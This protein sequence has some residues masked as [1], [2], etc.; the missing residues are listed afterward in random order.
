MLR[1]TYR[2]FAVLLTVLLSMGLPAH[3]ADIWVA[4]DGNDY[5]PG[6]AS[7]PF[8]TVAAALRY[9]REL[10]RLQHP[11]VQK[12]IHIKI[13][14]GEYLLP[15][16]LLLRP[17][18]AG[19][20]E[21][22]TVL[23][24]ADQATP[25][26]SGGVR[27]QGWQLC[28]E[29]V[30]GLPEAA[31]GKV[32]VAPVP[33]TAGI[34]LAFRQCWV[35]GRKAVRARNIMSDED[36]PRIYAVDK[37][38]QEMCIP[39]DALKGIKEPRQLEM[40]IHQ[41]WAIANLRV[42]SFTMEGDTACLHFYQPESRIQFEHPWPEAVIDAQH[43]KNG[44]S[45]FYLTNHISFLDQPGEWYE[46]VQQGKLYY[47]PRNGETMQHAE[48]VVPALEKLVEVKG[49]ADRPVAY[50]QFKGI[51]FA[52]STWMRPSLKGHV[53]LQAGMYLLDGYKLQQPGTP[54]KKSLENQAWIGRPPAAVELSYVHHTSFEGCRFEHLAST[55]LDYIRGTHDDTV[56][57]NLFS[58]IGGTG[59]QLGTYADEA[60]ETHLP[61][62]PKDE[63]EICTRERIS[64][65]L[66]TGCT[67]EDWGCVGISAGYVRDCSITH[68]EVREVSYSGIC[69]GWGWT[70][71]PNCMRNNRIE[72]NH[73]H[74]YARHMFDV[75][76]IY[77][78]SAQPGTVITGNYIDSIYHPSYA[79]DPQHWFYFYF[80]E[81]SSYITIRDN[82]CPSE[83]FMRN[84]NGPGNT[85]QNNGPMADVRIKQTA[86]IEP[87][88]QYLFTGKRGVTEV[89][90]TIRTQKQ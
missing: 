41:M 7:R 82:W 2:F 27:I 79:H 26:L 45:A 59:I 90:E 10:R 81:G 87:R 78:L 30:P 61:Y 28:T 89:H 62:Q 69:V 42:Q 56:E 15:E 25:V 8:A 5:N 19:T 51:C 70:K 80:D 52:Y 67:N 65:N 34:P 57:G 16:T 1:N 9:A 74:H 22:P 14:G 60:F 38:K 48:V 32:W 53:P 35:N 11:S 49:L 47:W 23:E 64:N 73:V 3:A 84:A 58:D 17:E 72:A 55:G 12:G 33:V 44:N 71:Q 85:W 43:R 88:F 13:K 6:T 4:T 50:V 86:G 39:A 46:D 31:R 75:G 54:E 36:M 29:Q 24:A 21:S 63:R 76:G 66:V 20:A 37:N 40:V 83:K 77:T 18:D 68:N